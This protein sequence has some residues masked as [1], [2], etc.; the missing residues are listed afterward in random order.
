[1]SNNPEMLTRKEAADY[2]G[3]SANTLSSWASNGRVK[4]PFVR[5]GRAVRYRRRDLDRFITSGATD[6]TSEAGAN[7]AS[8]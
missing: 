8:A 5:L 2:L 7:G 1:M 4:L 6:Q 3:L